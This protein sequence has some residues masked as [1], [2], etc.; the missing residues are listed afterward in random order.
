MSTALTEHEEKAI[1]VD[2]P[3]DAT[4]SP[5]QAIAKMAASGVGTEVVEQMKSLV[6]WD[7]AR[8]AKAEFNTAFSRA[9]QQFKQA[10]QSG[11]NKHLNSRYSKL[12]DYDDATREALANNGL[13]W[14][15]VPESLD[16]GLTKVTCILAHE[17]GHSETA[18]MVADPATMGN[19]AVNAL[20]SVGVV[21]TYLKRITLASLLGLVS[22]SEFDNDGN[23]PPINEPPKITAKQAADLRCLVE[24][25]G[26]D[27][28][29]FL[30]WTGKTSLAEIPASQMN[31][32][33]EALEGKRK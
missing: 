2:Q 26:V 29:K 10:K 9:K 5:I 14:R 25:I 22:D 16:N 12:E 13:S 4:D 32:C 15:H 24:E 7:D 30:R 21:T 3:I 11:E 31:R 33:V 20:Q 6:E 17:S 28:E 1:T 23:T 27:M 8:K 19:N 18:S